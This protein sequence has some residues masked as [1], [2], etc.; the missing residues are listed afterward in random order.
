MKNFFLLI[1]VYFAINTANAQEI[2]SQFDYR[3]GTGISLLGTGDMRTLMVE[4]E[5]NYKFNWYL[6]TSVSLAYA[7]SNSGVFE[8]SSFFQGNL[9]FYLSPFKNDGKGDFRIGAGLS[10]YD[11]SDTR[12]FRTENSP[13]GFFVEYAYDERQAVGA[14]ILLEYTRTLGEKWL[15]GIKSFTQPYFNGDINSGIL[16]KV[17]RVL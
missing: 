15:L 6:A 3:L 16:L 17:G 2:S 5:L 11:V 12:I 8:A 1:I 7:K 13:E 9:N 10:T 14:N 4:N